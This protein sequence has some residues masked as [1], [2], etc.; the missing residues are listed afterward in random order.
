MINIHVKLT[1]LSQTRNQAA[2]GRAFHFHSP[3]SH[4]G[5]GLYQAFD[6]VRLVLQVRVVSTWLVVIGG[7]DSDVAAVGA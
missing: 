1:E 6:D 7:A 5:G 3:R 4:P 2:G